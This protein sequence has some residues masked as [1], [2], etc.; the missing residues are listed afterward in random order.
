MVLT[1]TRKCPLRGHILAPPEGQ[2]APGL[3]RV[4]PGVDPGV[5]PGSQGVISRQFKRKKNFCDKR[6]TKY[7][8]RRMDAQT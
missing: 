6:S 4:N 5:D 1:L 2:R 7:E 8:V 3:P